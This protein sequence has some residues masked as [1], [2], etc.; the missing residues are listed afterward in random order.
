[1]SNNTVSYSAWQKLRG[2][3]RQ[4]EEYERGHDL[5]SSRPPIQVAISDQI[6]RHIIEEV[7]DLGDRLTELTSDLGR[8][9]HRVDER[10][11]RLEKVVE[12]IPRLSD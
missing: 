1:M 4:K 7:R 12:D 9:N 6:V 3:M 8:D 5:G 11:S 10:I 2:E